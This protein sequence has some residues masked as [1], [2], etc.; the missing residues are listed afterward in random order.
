M[1]GSSSLRSL[2]PYCVLLS[3]AVPTVLSASWRRSSSSSG[4]IALPFSRRD[5]IGVAIGVEHSGDGAYFVFTTVGQSSMSL[6]IATDLGDFV[7]ISAGCQTVSCK[8]FHSTL[9]NASAVFL[10]LTNSTVSLFYND[11]AAPGL[12]GQE[13]V[14]IGGLSVTDQTLAAIS[15]FNE[16]NL[17]NGTAGILGLGFPIQ[18]STAN[19]GTSP[20]VRSGTSLS[21]YLPPHGAGLVAARSS[22][23]SASSNTSA[24]DV[25]AQLY[26]H[27]PIITTL[28]SYGH[29]SEPIFSLTFNPNVS[30]A[31]TNE[32]GQLTIGTFPTGVD[33][34]SLTWAPV[35]L[36]DIG[37]NGSVPL[38]WE[39][40][41]DA[42][43]LDGNLLPGSSLV[44]KV[45][46]TV[47]T[48]ATATGG[49]KDAVDTILAA[50]SSTPPAC[51]GSHTLSFQ[52][53]GKL[54]SIAPQDLVTPTRR[55]CAVNVETIDSLSSNSTLYSWRLGAPF[56]RSNLVAFHYGNL[57]HPSIEPPRM[58]FMR[59]NDARSTRTGVG[60]AHCGW[61][62]MV[63]V[64]VGMI[65]WF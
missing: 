42:V 19:L 41:I 22:D 23:S 37:L 59:S 54:F 40:E 50:I 24:S 33:N 49:P 1:L 45:T 48:T 2:T 38:H 34:S 44:P 25:L 12:I 8:H 63:L 51:N 31:G 36:Y 35:R 65:L 17:F 47:D 27:G 55:G 29:I 5:T 18:S 64:G 32:S 58:G 60:V 57:T 10:P 26:A 43:F 15:S 53:G 62:A 21:R 39:V 52:I 30:H 20:Y 11:E 13:L 3:L 28:S 7:A 56:L 6:S 16:S 4:E 14:V 9:Y 46:A 61:L